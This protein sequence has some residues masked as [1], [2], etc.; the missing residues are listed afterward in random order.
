MINAMERLKEFNYNENRESI[1]NMLELGKYLVGA[2]EVGNKLFF[3]AN[4]KTYS[5]TNSLYVKRAIFWYTAEED[6][7]DYVSRRNVYKFG[8][9]DPD[10]YAALVLKNLKYNNKNKDSSR[11]RNAVYNSTPGSIADPKNQTS[12]ALLAQLQADIR[13]NEFVMSTL[14]EQAA[15]QGFDDNKE[16]ITRMVELGERLVHGDNNT[17]MSV[18]DQQRALFWY[19]A[20]E[21][22]LDKTVRQGN[23]DIDH[24]NHTLIN[25]VLTANSLTIKKPHAVALAAAKKIPAHGIQPVLFSETLKGNLIIQRNAEY[26][27]YHARKQNLGRRVS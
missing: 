17:G 9:P 24:I 1:R 26:S 11:D 25:E 13:N 22:L 6:F 12:Q 5:I 20:V 10:F 19:A 7:Y 21:T 18:S 27:I 16:T 23:V 8:D 3:N 15:L 2:K 14:Y 4:G